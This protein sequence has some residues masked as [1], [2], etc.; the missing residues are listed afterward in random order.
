MPRITSKGPTHGPD[1]IPGAFEYSPPCVGWVGSGNAL[2]RCLSVEDG[3]DGYDI[4]EGRV[5]QRYADIL[6]YEV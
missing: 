1:G 3:F 2:T 4:L 6:A 5:P